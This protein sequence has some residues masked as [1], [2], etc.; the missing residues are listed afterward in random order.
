ML[1]KDLKKMSDEEIDKLFHE[2]MTNEEVF[3]EYRSRLN[4]KTPPEF[5]S[6]EEEIE[7]LE[8]LVSQTEKN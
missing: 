3:E 5:S 7:F 8:K 1:N 2:D 6:K 4:W